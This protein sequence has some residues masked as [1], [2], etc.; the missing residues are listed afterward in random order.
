MADIG[1]REKFMNLRNVEIDDYLDSNGKVRSSSQIQRLVL[2]QMFLHSDRYSRKLDELRGPLRLS[3]DA[4]RTAVK[5]LVQSGI[6]RVTKD[7]VGLPKVYEIDHVRIAEMQHSKGDATPGLT[8]CSEQTVQSEG[9]SRTEGVSV[10][11]RGSVCPGQ[12]HITVRTEDRTVNTDGV[13]D[14]DQP[15]TLE[16]DE[17]ASS[18]DAISNFGVT[19]PPSIDT[20]EFRSAWQEWLSYQLQ[21]N[22]TRYPTLSAQKTLMHL[23]QFSVSQA[24]EKIERAIASNW[25]GC[26]Y[27]QRQSLPIANAIPRA[28]VASAVRPDSFKRAIP[29]ARA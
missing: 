14:S 21:K 11:D 1:V 16:G 27:P 5:A 22:G 24:I 29:K 25:Q 9:L 26:C 10:Q 3:L 7:V 8:L 28:N 23:S 15:R 2:Y 19:I 18:K 6:L 17:L 13:L 12:T 4:V 20:A